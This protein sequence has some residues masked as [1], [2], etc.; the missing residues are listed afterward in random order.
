M[1]SFHRLD[2]SYAGCGQE[3]EAQDLF[4]SEPSARDG[5][6][7]GHMGSDPHG[8]GRLLVGSGLGGVSSEPR[9]GEGLSAITS[10]RTCARAPRK[11]TIG[12]ATRVRS[13]EAPKIIGYARQLPAERS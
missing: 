6:R 3:M 10:C 2:A 9:R 11:Q 8:C 7:V 5:P 4:N 12:A 13:R 1:A